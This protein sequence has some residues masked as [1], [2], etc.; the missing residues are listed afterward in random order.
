MKS[1]YFMKP[2]SFKCIFVA[3]NTLTS[4]TIKPEEGP[5]FDV[6]YFGKHDPVLRGVLYEAC[7]APDLRLVDGERI[8]SREVQALFFP[9]EEFRVVWDPAFY[10]KPG[11]VVCR[12]CEKWLRFD[13]DFHLQSLIPHRPAASFARLVREKNFDALV[14]VIGGVC[15]LALRRAGGSLEQVRDA[16][17]LKRLTNITKR[18]RS[19]PWLSSQDCSWFTIEDEETKASFQRLLSKNAICTRE[20]NEGEIEIALSW[21]AKADEKVRGGGVRSGVVK[22]G[23][24]PKSGS[25]A[26][27]EA[28]PMLRMDRMIDF[29]ELPC[30]MWSSVSWGPRRLELPTMIRAFTMSAAMEYAKDQFVKCKDVRTFVVF[31]TWGRC[32]LERSGSWTC[33]SPEGEIKEIMLCLTN[34]NLLLVD[35]K[36][37]PK[38][39]VFKKWTVCERKRWPELAYMMTALQQVDVVVGI[40]LYEEELEWIPRLQLLKNTHLILVRI[41][42][43][44]R[45]AQNMETAIE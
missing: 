34:P 6:M 39:D 40:F 23:V 15:P 5:C 41:V 44:G 45:K 32:G 31:S 9:G 38:E 7:V 25:K 26:V 35:K 10:I 21:A 37:I 20:T 30:T 11:R 16:A 1:Q 2:V 12:E 22:S 18:L 33:M 28:D 19:S 29:R 13:L 3:R 42:G 24:E 27:L 43:G 4:W 14:Y 17:N 8:W 36:P